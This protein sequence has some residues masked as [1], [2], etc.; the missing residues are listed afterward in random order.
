MLLKEF[1]T[2]E[3]IRGRYD[4]ECAEIRIKADKID[5]TDMY[6]KDP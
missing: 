2:C 5:P 3:T 4:L 6:I 1:R